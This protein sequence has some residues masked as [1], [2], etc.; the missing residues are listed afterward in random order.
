MLLAVFKEIN[1]TTLF[2]QKIRDRKV[3]K[4]DLNFNKQYV[5][6]KNTFEKDIDKKMSQILELKEIK[7]ILNKSII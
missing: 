4:N 2:C 7:L 5:K 6:K 1:F 3:D